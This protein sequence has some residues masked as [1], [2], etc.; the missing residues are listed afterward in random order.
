MQPRR[1][2]G[3]ARVSS[4]AQ[5]QGT[6]LADQQASITAYAKARGL[7]VTKFFVETE[8]GIRE[9]TEQREQISRLMAEVRKGDLVLCD[10]LDRWSRDP[11]F[12]HTSIQRIT[13]M[14]AS[15]YAVS[16]ALDPDSREGGMMLSVRAMIAKEEHTRIRER[17]VG[18]RMLL[19]DAG[20]Y[21]EGVTPFGYQRP[22][23]QRGDNAARNVLILHE[24]N[25]AKVRRMFELSAA[26]MKLREVAA[27]VGE[28]RDRVWSVLRNRIHTGFMT[29]S[30]GELIRGRHPAIVSVSLFERSRAKLE[31]RRN[32]GARPRSTP[33]RTMP[34][35]IRDVARCLVC[36]ARMTSAYGGEPVYRVDYYLCNGRKK[37]VCTARLVR[38]DQV[39]PTFAGLVA[40]RICELRDELAR[41]PATV[42]RNET[43]TEARRERLARK[44][45]R[46]LEAFT[47]GLMDRDAMR[48]AVGR[49]DIDLARLDETDAPK[50]AP[51][52]EVRRAML[53][54]VGNLRLAWSKADDKE[55]RAIVNIVTEAALIE[56]DKS[57]VAKW[58]PADEVLGLVA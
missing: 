30:K 40:D 35:I 2:F 43:D 42:A 55:R 25:A 46:T 26:G 9:K 15:F 20:Y 34:W 24:E 50:Q 45:A 14:G 1:V 44:R 33:S 47:D 16:D 10:K 37:K 39:E 52:R 23:K 38:R 21:V 54:E 12:S 18:T 7:T 51:T 31:G 22:P 5:A 29:S 13:D 4:I 53:R 28:S 6:S 19:R 3:Y 17:T 57:P 49:I 11:G 56:R 32:G 48:E 58:K 27:Q 8:S 41:E 36:G